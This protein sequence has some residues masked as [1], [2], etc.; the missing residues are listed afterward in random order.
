MNI[1]LYYYRYKAPDDDPYISGSA[2]ME[3]TMVTGLVVDESEL[4]ELAQ[5]VDQF[6]TAYDIEDGKVKLHFD[7]I[8]S[9][10]YICVTLL[11]WEQFKVSML[12]P[13]VFRVYEFHAPDEEC[14]TLFNPLA[15]QDLVNV[16]TG[17]QCKCIQAT[18]PT[19]QQKM[20]T[21]ITADAR[22]EAACK[23]DIT[24][25]YKVVVI[26]SVEDGDFVKYT[27]SILDIY[28]KGGD[29][30]KAKKEVK[31]IKK[32]TCTDIEITQGEQYLIM[33]KEGIQIRFGFDFQYEYALDADTWVEWW[34]P[35]CRTRDCE[36]FTDTL[37]EFS[38]SMLFDHC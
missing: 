24:F 6:V 32:K 33:G 25:A 8:P 19:A 20:D 5:R 34:P 15:S 35:A 2:V 27:A 37:S 7:G 9:D 14:T 26:T 21:S 28:K 36:E 31:F 3:I 29:F 10:E 11:A 38:E 1:T 22:K 4:E 30:V 18:C 12:S 16:C 13:G 23:A 17:N